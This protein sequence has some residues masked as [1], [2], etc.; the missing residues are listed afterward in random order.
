MSID[1]KNTV[2]RQIDVK[3]PFLEFAE[4]HT[5][6]ALHGSGV[7]KLFDVVHLLYKNSMI[8]MSTS[9][10]S[11]ILEQAV[12]RHQPPLVQGRRVKLKY[13]HQGGHNPPTIVIHGNQTKALP[14]AY[15]RYLINLYRTKLGLAGTPVRVL[16]KSPD[17]PFQ[18]KKNTL[19]ERQLKKRK[20]LIKHIKKRK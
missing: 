8:D 5:I 16:F 7:G 14:D 19:T 9:L 3:L 17:N 6:S 10:L 4:K 20:R 12:Q 2:N 18:G 1:Q 13:A 11:S 15:K